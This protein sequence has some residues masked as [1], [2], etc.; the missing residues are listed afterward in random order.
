MQRKCCCMIWRG[1]RC[2]KED[3]PSNA[4]RMNDPHALRFTVLRIT[5][6]YALRI[7]LLEESP[8]FV[9]FYFAILPTK[10]LVE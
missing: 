1:A 4:Q 7:T 2:R 8:Q 6:Y 3:V 9:A 10:S 5:R